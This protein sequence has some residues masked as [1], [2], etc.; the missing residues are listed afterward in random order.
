MDRRVRVVGVMAVL[1]LLPV[2]SAMGAGTS[3]VVVGTVRPAISPAQVKVYLQPPA[4]FDEIAM[5]EAT[6]LWAWAFTE[7]GKMDAAMARLK[8]AAARLGANG[9]LLQSAGTKSAG[10]V[11]TGNMTANTYGG[12]TYANGTGVTTP[13]T[14]AAGSAIAIYVHDDQKVADRPSGESGSADDAVAAPPAVIAPSTQSGDLYDQLLKLDE[15]RTK[16]IL[17][18]EEFD[19]QK[20]K[21]LAGQ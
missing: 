2:L 7:Q 12:T 16:G 11:S 8:A 19:E 18:Q 3:V 9:L 21:I 15:L 14:L 4:E 17:T 1:V 5:V 6:S 13:V 10:G 20:K